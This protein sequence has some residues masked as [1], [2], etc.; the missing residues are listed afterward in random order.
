MGGED[1]YDVKANAG[2]SRTRSDGSAYSRDTDAVSEDSERWFAEASGGVRDDSVG[3]SGDAGYDV[4]VLRRGKTIRVD[5][6]HAGLLPDGAPR[7]GA[8][9]NLIVNADSNKL[10]ASDLLVFIEGPP[11]RVVGGLYTVRFLAIAKLQDF[12]FGMKFAVHASRLDPWP[13]FG[14][15]LKRL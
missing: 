3:L 15:P 7:N 10:V 4:V 1:R 9:S 14:I 13:V 5:V 2:W 12:G 11:F 6:V 8:A